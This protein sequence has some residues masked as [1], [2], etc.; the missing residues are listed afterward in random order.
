M[1]FL[2]LSL[3]EFLALLSGVSGLVVALYLLSRSRRRQKVATLRFWSQAAQPV[4]STRRRRIQQPWSLVLQLICMTLLLLAM[5]QLKWGDRERASRDH[6]LVLDA[7]SWTGARIGEKTIGDE[8]RSRARQYVRSLSSS[9]RVMVVRADGLPSPVTGMES[10]R[11]VIERAIDATRPGASALDLNAALAFATQSRQLNRSAGGEIVFVGVPRVGSAGVPV[12]TPSNLRVLAVDAPMD[13]V[14]FTNIGVRRSES[15]AD[16]WNILLTVRNYSRVPQRVPLSVMFGG[17]VAGGTVLNIAPGVAESYAFPLRTRAAG[18]IDARI[19]V[20]DSLTD[21]NRAILELPQHKVLKIKVFTTEPE[22]LRPALA[23]HGQVQAEYLPPSAWKDD[24]GADV[25]VFDRFNPKSA[26]K[27]PAIWIEPPGDSPFRTASRIAGA[28]HVSWRSDHEI[29]AGI[30]NRDLRLTE[31]QVLYAN[32]EDVTLASVEEGPVVLLRP[33][34]RSVALGFHPGRTDMKFNLTTPLLFANVLRWL[35][36]DVFSGNELHAGSVGTVTLPLEGDTD[37]KDIKV[38][39]DTT[40]LPY[41]VQNNSLRFFAGA[42]GIVRVIS[43]GREQ[44]FSLSLPEIGDKTWTPP[45]NV[46]TGLPG[47]FERAAARDL[48]Q[49]LAVIGALGLLIE[50]WLYGRRRL[51]APRFDGQSSSAAAASTTWRHAS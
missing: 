12:S 17:A 15:A 21:D 24:A 28:K 25:V 47:V 30:R 40:E 11:A 19:L 10:D 26:T 49:V 33:K 41:T 38:L 51:L 34:A 42:P 1:F 29:T 6:V 48:W 9:D 31:G 16:A 20:R 3:P 18:W 37:P 36:P 50:W 4:P 5:A 13:N 35:R 14:G 7:S 39:L 45:T 22:T 23:A 46:R 8:V 2:N 43:P 27:S 32:A 44:V